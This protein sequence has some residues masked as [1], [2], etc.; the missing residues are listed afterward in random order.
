MKN[1]EL[2]IATSELLNTIDMKESMF[3]PRSVI[4]RISETYKLK[5][6]NREE[7]CS[8]R[9]WIVKYFVKYFNE[10][11][12]TTNDLL[13]Y[14]AIIYTMN[15]YVYSQCWKPQIDSKEL[16]KDF[17]PINDVYGRIIVDDN[18]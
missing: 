15:D 2:E 11:D 16:L 7:L 5:D 17:K 18:D 3:V 13:V 4:S 1:K 9:M 14:S 10:N 12:S 6:L 8:L